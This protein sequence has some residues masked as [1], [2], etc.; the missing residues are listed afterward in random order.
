MD[1][2][3]MYEYVTSDINIVSWMICVCDGEDGCGAGSA[4]ACVWWCFT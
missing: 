2:C 1:A 3:Q 4:C